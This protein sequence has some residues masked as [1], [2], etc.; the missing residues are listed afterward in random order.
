MPDRRDFL[1][2]AA[3]LAAAPLGAQEKAPRVFRVGVI[4]TV[5]ESANRA[6]MAELREE[7]DDSGYRDGRNLRIEY[8]S[9]DGLSQ[10]YAALAAELVRL[11]VDCIVANGTPAALAAKAATRTIPIVAALALDPVETGLVASLD[12]PGGN[13]TGLA[14]LTPELEKR[15][16]ELLR[17]L[18]PGRK[19]FAMLVNMG[20][21]ALASSWK[22]LQAAAV[23]LG[24]MPDLI[25]VRRAQDFARAVAAARTRDAEAL[26]V[27]VGP[28]GEADRDA[29]LQEVARHGFPAIYAQR[30]FADAGGMASYGINLPYN[31]GRTVAFVEKILRGAKAA[32][33]PM[34]QPAKFEFVV[35]RRTMRA[36][37]LAIP[38]DLLLRSDAVVG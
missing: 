17:A 1:A 7:L 2:A 25:D 33:L 8:R 10:R 21:P 31:F 36:L 22:A 12:K 34:E 14:V 16:I 37:G 38:P 19:R 35:N 9:A 4:D 20:N 24:L 18:A 26:V 15:R 29:L 28:L 32:E 27:R 13:V 5:A 30:G 6:A 11:R 23:D 3:A